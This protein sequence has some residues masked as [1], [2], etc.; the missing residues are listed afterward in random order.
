MLCAASLLFFLLYLYL[1]APELARQKRRLFIKY[2]LSSLCAGLLGCFI[3]LPS[4]LGISGGRLDQTSITQFT[5]NENMPFLEMGA[6]LFTGANN[7]DEL[8]NG[9]PNLY[10]G[11]LPLALAILFF[12]SKKTDGRKKRAA[13][14]ALGFYLLCLFIVAFN[15]VMHGGTV[16]N[17]FNYRYSFVFSFLLLLIAAEAWQHLDSYTFEDC[18]HCFFILLGFA[19]LVFSK[20]YGFVS[21]GA[22]VLDLGLLLLMYL[23]FRMHRGDAEKN[24]QRVFERLILLLCSFQLLLN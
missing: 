8:V 24:P 11:I 10:V 20:R 6:K 15:L 14:V 22:V 5:F 1:H 2:A 12:L 17:W 21:G 16:T 19:V 13:G 18:K 4:L 7:T 23:A 3:W 9:L